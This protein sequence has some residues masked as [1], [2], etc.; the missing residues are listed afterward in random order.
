MSDHWGVTGGELTQR[1]RPI[2]RR[3]PAPVV[4]GFML[5]VLAGVVTGCATGQKQ[6][7]DVVWPPPP[8]LPRIKYVG[9]ISSESDIE[10]PSAARWFR[11]LLFGPEPPARMGKPYGVA[12]DP[13]G[14]LLVADSAWGK[15]MVFDP[16]QGKFSLLGLS[17]PGVLSKPLGVTADSQGKIYVTDTYQNRAV[18]Y[19]RDGNFLL[20]IGERGRFEQPVGIA[21]NEKLGRIYIVDT[22]KHNV[23]VFDMEGNFL[24]EFGGRGAEDGQFNF[25]TNIAVSRQSGTVAV[26]D[27]FNFRVQLFDP[28]GKFIRKFGGVGTALGHFSKPKG[29]GFDSADH[30]YVVDAAFNNVQIFD[31]EGRLLLFFGRMGTGPGEFWLPAGLAVDGRD[32]IYVADQY[33]RKIQI[34][35][36]I[37]EPDV[38][39]EPAPASAPSPGEQHPLPEG[40]KSGFKASHKPPSG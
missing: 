38:V 18:V 20:G 7:Q 32:K 14:R 40:Q 21:V 30:I 26:M 9:S 33:N 10:K 5:A 6:Q 19:D 11:D 15:V 24:F 8:D 17:G 27:S 35:Q 3:W 12:V 37:P 22:K 29:I 23:S 2:G 28:D 34:F 36:Y 39:K 31:L 4:V 25:P 16:V 1:S 13:A